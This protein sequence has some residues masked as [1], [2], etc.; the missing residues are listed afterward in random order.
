[1]WG[2]GKAP[3]PGSLPAGHRE[4][5]DLILFSIDTMRADHLGC[6]GYSRDTSPFFDSLARV[7]TRF[8]SAWAP[9]PWTLPSHATMLTGALSP[10]HG[11]IEEEHAIA[12]DL[13]LLSESLSEAGYLCC[14]VVTSI[15]VSELYGFGRGFDHF[16]DFG[17]VSGENSGQPPPRSA[18]V[19]THALEWAREQAEGQP[20]FLFLH[21]YDVHYPYDAPPPWNEKF[22]RPS[23]GEEL[24]YENYYH[25]L[26]HPPTPEQFDQQIGQYDEEIAYVDETWSRFHT[27]WTAARPN[28]ICLITS[29]HGEE[30]GERGSWG[31]A[32]TL[33]PELLQVPWIVS[34][35]GVR[36]QTVTERVGLEDLAPTLAGLAGVSFDPVDG[37]DRTALIRDG[38]RSTDD[39]TAARFASTYRRHTWLHRWHEDGH[40]LVFNLPRMVYRLYDLNHDP[41]AEHDRFPA[42][43]D[44]AQAMSLAMYSYLEQPWEATQDGVVRSGNGLFVID[45]Q[46]Q[47]QEMIVKQGQRFALFPPDAAVTWYGI[48]DPL[49]ENQRDVQSGPWQALGGALPGPDDTGLRWHGRLPTSAD[50][51]LTTDQKERLRALGY[52]E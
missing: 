32:H 16:H 7:G 27:T 23:T 36:A 3:S 9:S 30:F 20:L 5:P 12:G 52:V 42:D 46:R 24:H 17:I 40:D 21:V 51:E 45:G 26:R 8:A 33:A 31:H 13:T 18:D 47:N 49:L 11:A 19:L 34:G 28:T 29:D 38:I 15:F 1:M 44:R 22:N 37:R 10:R 50:T 14:G 39:P 25:Y 2:C 4:R 48:D 43:L 41:H 35:P 6:Y